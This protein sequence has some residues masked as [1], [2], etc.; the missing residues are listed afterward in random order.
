MV[1][2]L[3]LMIV[4][5]SNGQ[6]RPGELSSGCYLPVIQRATR[7]TRG[8]RAHVAFVPAAAL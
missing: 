5:L 1:E 6:A 8:P 3:G 4:R 7:T 2:N